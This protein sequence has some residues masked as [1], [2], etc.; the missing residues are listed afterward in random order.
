MEALK[1]SPDFTIN[2]MIGQENN[3]LNILFSK[4][5]STVLSYK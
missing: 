2:R 3:L 4:L 1:L 5:D